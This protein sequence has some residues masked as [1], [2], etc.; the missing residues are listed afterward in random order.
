M[1]YYLSL[2]LLLYHKYFK[3]FYIDS[4]N[5]RAYI[6]FTYVCMY[7]VL[8]S[9]RPIWYIF[10][11]R[12][13]L[14]FS[15]FILYVA[16]HDFVSESFNYSYW[17]STAGDIR[18]YTLEE[19]SDFSDSY[20]LIFLTIAFHMIYDIFPGCTTLCFVFFLHTFFFTKCIYRYLWFRYS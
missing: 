11:F 4:Y 1:F 3:H 16:L 19:V 8:P 14:F 18:L 10:P 15:L 20:I 13:S 17:I 9:L 2:T 7:N 6:G 5:R 12:Y